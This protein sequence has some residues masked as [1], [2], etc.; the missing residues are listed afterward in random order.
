VTPT[1]Q[2][3][4]T[5]DDTPAQDLAAPP[6][7]H[8]VGVNNYARVIQG[9]PA[10]V[11]A[12]QVPVCNILPPWKIPISACLSLQE[13]QG[14][15]VF[16]DLAQPPPAGI[17]PG[18]LNAWPHEV[19]VPGEPATEILRQLASRYLDH[20]NSTVDTVRVELSPAGGFRVI[21]ALEI[22]VGGLL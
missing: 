15:D 21:I 13:I 12:P 8:D 6:V 19:P 1:L 2:G 14:H 11:I 10:Q 9:V 4:G 17:A 5:V 7:Y 22:P 20:P 3:L 16:G 18:G